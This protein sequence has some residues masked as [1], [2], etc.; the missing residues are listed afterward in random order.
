MIALFPAVVIGSTTGTACRARLV[1]RPIG[2]T[3]YR[4][5]H[6]VGPGYFTLGLALR[7]W[8]TANVI[9]IDTLQTWQAI[10]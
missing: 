1:A 7:L 2:R 10:E 8:T 6:R 5:W 4:L 3:V 9:G